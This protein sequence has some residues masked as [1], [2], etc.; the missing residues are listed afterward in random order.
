MFDGIF[1]LETMEGF[2]KTKYY[3]EVTFEYSPL[4]K[5]W[6]G[7][8]SCVQSLTL[9]VKTLENIRSMYNNYE[10]TEEMRNED[11]HNIVKY[12]GTFKD[13][14]YD[15]HTAI[16][17]PNTG[18]QHRG[19]GVSICDE[20]W[21]NDLKKLIRNYIGEHLKKQY[22]KSGKLKTILCKTQLNKIY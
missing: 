7:F 5:S 15:F 20:Y 10:Y 8:P 6:K 3:P 1:D 22:T 9:D 21:P 17:N 4:P 2:P 16:N 11:F 12:L 13:F 14:P 18:A 19:N